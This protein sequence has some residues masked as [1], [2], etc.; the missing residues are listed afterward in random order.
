M[1]KCPEDRNRREADARTFEILEF[2]SGRSTLFKLGAYAGVLNVKFASQVIQRFR[3]GGESAKR[4]VMSQFENRECFM[5]VLVGFDGL[6]E[7][8]RQTTGADCHGI[9]AAEGLALELHWERERGRSSTWRN[10]CTSPE[11]GLLILMMHSNNRCLAPS[12]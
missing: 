11:L 7:A 5:R 3:S 1:S 6:A 8:P 9:P 4:H 12:F 10:I 2:L